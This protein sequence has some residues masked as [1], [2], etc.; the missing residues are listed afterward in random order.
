[1]FIA[2]EINMGFVLGQQKICKPKFTIVQLYQVP[3]PKP[4]W[5]QEHSQVGELHDSKQLFQQLHFEWQSLLQLG[6]QN[7]RLR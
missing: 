3:L 1:M 2:H 6:G 4:Q 7:I 5:L